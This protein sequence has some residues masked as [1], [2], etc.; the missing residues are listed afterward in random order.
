M[1]SSGAMLPKRSRVAC[2]L[3]LKP[4]ANLLADWPMS[5]LEKLDRILFQPSIVAVCVL[6]VW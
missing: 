5:M 1:I 6:V 3:E 2:R 4:F